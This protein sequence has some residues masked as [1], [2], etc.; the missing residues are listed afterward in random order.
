MNKIK[1]KIV[2]TSWDDGHPLDIKL[3][4]LFKKYDIPAT[5]YI[6]PENREGETMTES[7]IKNIS[8]DFD[9][10]GHTYTHPD[11]T[12]L[13]EKKAFNEI[14]KGKKR[15]EEITGQEVTSFCYP[16]GRYNKKIID[17]VKKAG[18]KG[19]RT[20]HPLRITPNQKLF[21]LGVTVGF[22]QRRNTGLIVFIKNPTFERRNLKFL[23]DGEKR[24]LKFFLDRLFSSNGSRKEGKELAYDALD[25][26][27][28]NEGILH[29]W[30][31]SWA[32]EE[33]QKWKELEKLLAYIN[34]KSKNTELTFLNNTQLIKLLRENK[35][36]ETHA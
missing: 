12:K 7:Q 27:V 35:V 14:K 33:N 28:K 30:G 11:L 1:K 20:T 10:G 16:K 5:F 22:A 23:L 17:L 34:K 29:I 13:S 24:N 31:H 19:A 4:N 6:S 9:V 26:L 25:Y 8:E 3:A 36:G 21:E 18:F 2:T 15:L 32:I